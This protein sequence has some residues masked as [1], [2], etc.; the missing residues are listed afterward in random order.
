VLSFIEAVDHRFERISIAFDKANDSLTNGRDLRI[1]MI[2]E[3]PEHLGTSV[4][5]ALEDIQ[6]GLEH[7][8]LCRRQQPRLTH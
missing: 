6:R 4:Q 8:L 2:T 1:M 5:H 7:L 3:A